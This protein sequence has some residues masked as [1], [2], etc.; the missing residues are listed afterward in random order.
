MFGFGRIRAGGAQRFAAV[1]LAEEI[2]P[3]EHGFEQFER[4]QQDVPQHVALFLHVFAV[5]FSDAVEVA[6][7]VGLRHKKVVLFVVQ[8]GFEFAVGQVQAIDGADAVQ[9][10]VVGVGQAAGVVIKDVAVFRIETR[11][12][13]AAFAFGNKLKAV[14][15]KRHDGQM[16]V[17]VTIAGQ[18]QCQAF[19]CRIVSHVVYRAVGMPQQEAFG[20]CQVVNRFGLYRRTALQCCAVYQPAVGSTDRIARMN[21]RQIQPF[22]PDAHKVGAAALGFP[23]FFAVYLFQVADILLYRLTRY[24]LAAAV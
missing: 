5:R 18:R 13:V 11:V 21:V 4:Y 2:E 20:L 14:A 7:V 3:A 23:F 15:R 9:C 19:V 12:A 8:Y 22:L 24:R 16:P 17:A 10:A 6:R 1:A